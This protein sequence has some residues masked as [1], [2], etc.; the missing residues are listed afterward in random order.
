MADKQAE[1]RPERVV[2]TYKKEFDK[3]GKLKVSQ[4]EMMDNAMS[5]AA[6]KGYHKIS[7]QTETPEEW[8]V[9]FYS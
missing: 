6:K 2:V 5:D 4:N 7:V 8:T 9:M 1:E 3:E